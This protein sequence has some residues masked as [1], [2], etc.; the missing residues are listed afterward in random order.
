[1]TVGLRTGWR[2]RAGVTTRSR[3]RSP[4]AGFGESV[5]KRRGALSSRP[6]PM[7]RLRQFSVSDQRSCPR[8]IT[9]RRSPGPA[10]TAGRTGSPI[11]TD[12]SLPDRTCEPAP[13]SP[14]GGTGIAA[15]NSRENSSSSTAAPATTHATATARRSHTA[16]ESW[17]PAR[18]GPR[19]S[20]VD[21]AAPARCAIRRSAARSSRPQPRARTQARRST[22]RDAG[23]A[24]PAARRHRR[25]TTRVR[26]RPGIPLVQ[27]SFGEQPAQRSLPLPGRRPIDRV[28][29][30]RPG[31]QSVQL[32]RHV[33][34]MRPRGRASCER[35]NSRRTTSPSL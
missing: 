30:Q 29:G 8:A 32:D 23:I 20:E 16:P 27:P 6:Q 14:P 9:E 25:T 21:A 11:C 26:R 28:G 3:R 34:Q 35:A 12:W 4:A 10:E 5:R 7:P 17:D 33:P 18:L 24:R 15:A 13:A 2:T 1:M 22:Q 19:A 31:E